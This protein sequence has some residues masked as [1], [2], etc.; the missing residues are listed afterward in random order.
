MVHAVPIGSFLLSRVPRIAFGPGT[1]GEL[2]A[3][4]ARHGRHALLVRGGHSLVVAGRPLVPSDAMA[5]A[6]LEVTELAVSGEPT[7]ATIDAAVGGLRARRIDVVVGIGG[8]SVLDS[9]KAIAGLLPSGDSIVDHLEGVG[10]GQA[11]GSPVLPWIALPT[12]AGTGSEAT[13]N[14]VVSVPGHGKRSF[15]DER[16]IAAEAIVDPDLLAGCPPEQIAASGLDALTQLLEAYV[17]LRANPMTD[18]LAL[19][20]LLAAREGLLPWFRAVRD[21]TP[22]GPAAV[23]A[24]AAMAYAAL[25][26]GIALANAGLGATHGVAAALGG[27]YGIPH[28]VACGATLVATVRVNLGALEARDAGGTALP[29]YAELGRLLADE[30]RLPDPAARGRLIELLGAWARELGMPRLRAFGVSA[31]ALADLVPR[32]RGSSMRS[33]PVAL[34]DAEVDSILR[35]SL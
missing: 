29:R 10:P 2:G 19:S 34:D 9:A 7:P 30:P 6:G 4:A 32:C 18:A 27:Y 25:A 23:G 26:S 22:E 16:L 3:A 1:V 15:R 35:Q 13:R 17:S 11:L 5:A 21:G 28:G 8:G 24:R 33:N 31:E 12:T 20:G 14:A